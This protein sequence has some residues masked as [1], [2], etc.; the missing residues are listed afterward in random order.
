MTSDGGYE[1]SPSEFQIL[2][3]Q[4]IYNCIEE[5][6][7]PSNSKWIINTVALASPRRGHP[8]SVKVA[9]H[10]VGK[11]VKKSKVSQKN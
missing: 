9:W 6:N 11:S 4:Y 3:I 5:K 8:K 7:K 1:E 10:L 2:L